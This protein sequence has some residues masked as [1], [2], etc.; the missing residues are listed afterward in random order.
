MTETNPPTTASL[1]PLRPEEM[2]FE[3]PL[4][5]P[6]QEKPKEKQK[7]TVSESIFSPSAQME[8]MEEA[9][10]SFMPLKPE[11]PIQVKE[12]VTPQKNQ[13]ES[14]YEQMQLR[15]S[16]PTEQPQLKTQPQE[17]GKEQKTQPIVI[18]PPYMPKSREKADALT[19][20]EWQPILNQSYHLRE[21]DVTKNSRFQ[22]FLIFAAVVAFLSWAAI[23]P[24][25]EMATAPGQII[26]V[27]LIKSVQHLEGGIVKEIL[28]KEGDYVQQGD[29]LLRLDP[30]AFEADLS[31]NQKKQ[32][33]LQI[34]TERL[35]SFG[36]DKTPDFS[37]FPKEM[38]AVIDN[39]MSIYNMQQ[40]N[41]QDQR[42]V[43]LQQIAQQNAI[44]SVQKGQQKDFETQLHVVQEQRDVNKSLFEKRLKVRSEYL[45]SE[46]QVAK[47]QRELN[48]IINQ[49]QQ[50]QKATG[51]LESRLIELE[52]RLRNDALKEI[53]TIAGE[54]EELCQIIDRLQDKV[55][56]LEIKAPSSGIVKGLKNTT[57]RGI[58][59]S[60]MEILQIVP[61][62][63]LRWKQ[64]SIPKMLGMCTKVKKP[65]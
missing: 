30:T 5:T 36:L 22:I 16:Q 6:P 57:V 47:V 4:E 13:M 53:G 38:K 60:G 21:E 64:N 19:L 33:T 45:S 2:I 46:E 50:T 15:A 52:S 51:E 26:P 44:L 42:Q 27:G 49:M 25:H 37:T 61:P 28:V 34:R 35:K 31:Q 39:Q 65:W 8:R 17:K 14:S 24:I 43:M 18:M 1:V 20:K 10:S 59:Q 11:H 62:K 55:S 12:K 54:S 3:T 58:V 29:V 7:E 40:K 41:R 63:R 9:A 32:L 56:R 23:T 48:V